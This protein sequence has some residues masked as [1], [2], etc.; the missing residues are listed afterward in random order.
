MTNEMYKLMCETYLH[1]RR[2]AR[3]PKRVTLT[4]EQIAKVPK[5]TSNWRKIIY[6][7][8]QTTTLKFNLHAKNNNEQPAR[9]HSL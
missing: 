6:W 9:L 7:A 1:I 2:Q 3:E 8:D 5:P 4:A